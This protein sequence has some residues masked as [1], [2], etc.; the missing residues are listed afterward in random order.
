MKTMTTVKPYRAAGVPLVAIEC[1]DPAS[2]IASIAKEITNGTT[3]PLIQWDCIR[4]IIGVN[5]PG[6]D[7]ANTLND[8]QDAAVTTSNVC[9][10]LF[11]MQKMERA[12]CVMLGM[13]QIIA[14][15]QQGLTA[16]QALWNLRDQYRADD[17][18]APEVIRGKFGMSWSYLTFE[19]PANVPPEIRKRELA[20]REKRFEEMENECREALRLSMG[21]LVDHLVEQLTPAA[22]GKKKRFYDSTITKLIE[23]LSLVSARNVTGDAELESLAA[24]ANEIIANA[25]P[26]ELRTDGTMRDEIRN[27]MSAVKTQVTALIQTEKRRKFDLE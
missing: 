12:V 16:R 8:G 3:P 4:G 9:A 24:K 11:A 18:P 17:Y 5:E 6:E 21:E 2:V 23:F 14:D 10:A 1:A 15:P 27:K 25:T 26:D 7:L 22:D 20:E 13:A 19:V